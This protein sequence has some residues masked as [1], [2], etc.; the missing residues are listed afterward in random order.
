MKTPRLVP[1]LRPAACVKTAALLALLSLLSACQ[2]NPVLGTPK[3]VNPRLGGM[4]PG[5]TY[6]VVNCPNIS[7]TT[8]TINLVATAPTDGSNQCQVTLDSAVSLPKTLT[9]LVW[10][11]QATDTTYEYRFRNAVL[12]EPAGYGVRLIDN[13][14]Y[15]APATSS[16]SIPMQPISMQPISMQ[17][18]WVQQVQQPDEV[19]F[20]R[21]QRDW[22]PRISAYDVYLEYRAKG[23][24]D[25]TRCNT[26]DPV[27]INRE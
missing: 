3:P 11:L 18:I 22:P 27:I 15:V 17:P 19:L 10:K 4:N 26:Y 6:T 21:I 2:Q 5:E 13:L 7:G 16:A 8:C 9:T 23:A 24:R 1:P 20:S 12:P 25:W 14:M